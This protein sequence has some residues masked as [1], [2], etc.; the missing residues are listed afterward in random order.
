M[1]FEKEPNYL[2]SKFRGGLAPR[3]SNQLPYPY[4]IIWVRGGFFFVFSVSS[5]GY[6]LAPD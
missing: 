2:S 3:C 1:K 6:H 4:I 5:V